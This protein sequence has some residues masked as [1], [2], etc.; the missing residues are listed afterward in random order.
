MLTRERYLDALEGDVAAMA[1]HLTSGDLSAPVAGCP[2]WDLG[3]L[4][5]HLGVTHRWA[6]D[7]LG[8]Q[9]P[10]AEGSP[11]PRDELAAW[12]VDGA[13]RLLG[14]LRG[15]DPATECWGYGPK[16][17]TAAFWVRRQALETAVHVW[18]AAIALGRPARV[19]ADL[20]ADGVE[21]VARVF[22]PRQVRLG[23]REPLAAPVVLRCTDVGC[24]VLLGEGEAVAAIEAAA[25]PLLLLVWGRHDLASLAADGARLTGDEAAVHSALSVPLTP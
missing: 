24:D 11:P 4:G 22:Y 7:A 19:A 3:D 1:D 21:E 13:D 2:G 12:F 10:P 9:T 20:A 14:A 16:P 25:E 6:T 23:R 15:T 8:S 18:D 17:R 5:S